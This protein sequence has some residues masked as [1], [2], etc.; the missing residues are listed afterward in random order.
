MR[1]ILSPSQIWQFD[2]TRMG[3]CNDDLDLNSDIEQDNTNNIVA[4]EIHG[5][6]CVV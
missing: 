2:T 4:E 6:V 3:Q 1:R 5:D